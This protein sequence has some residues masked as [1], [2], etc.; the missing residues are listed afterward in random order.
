MDGSGETTVAIR[1]SWPV[2]G[3]FTFLYGIIVALFVGW[4][5]S[6]ARKHAIAIEIIAVLC[7]LAVILCWWRL[8]TRACTASR[9]G[10]RA[11]GFWRSYDVPWP[12]VHSLV[13][14]KYRVGGRWFWWA[15]V[16]VGFS[17]HAN[18]RHCVVVS[19]NRR[20]STPVT[21]ANHLLSNAPDMVRDRIRVVQ[22]DI[23]PR[24]DRPEVFYLVRWR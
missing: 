8:V 12:D 20:R 24:G 1:S 16:V 10:I 4:A 15:W 11:R 3:Y 17:D 13:A 2:I 19:A 9:A 14:T 22:A 6:V 18:R 21:K 23:G 5:A 7:G